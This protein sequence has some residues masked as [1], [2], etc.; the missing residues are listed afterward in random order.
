MT[1]SYP[2]VTIIQLSFPRVS[3]VF[4]V[5]AHC[6]VSRFIELSR[7]CSLELSAAS[8]KDA[9]FNF[10][11]YISKM[12]LS[13]SDPNSF[14]R[15]DLCKVTSIDIALTVNFVNQILSGCVTFNVEKKVAGAETLVRTSIILYYRSDVKTVKL[16][17]LLLSVSFSNLS[18]VTS[19]HFRNIRTYKI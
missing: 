4:T 8:S 12:A 6:C 17:L 19:C 10:P 1:C 16:F 5:V 9:L 15:P 11:R 18:S 13:P 2:E 14:S 3:S 7:D